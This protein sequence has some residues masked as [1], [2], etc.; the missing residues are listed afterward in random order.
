MIQIQM[1][2]K[3]TIL[4]HLGLAISFFMKGNQVTRPVQP[5]L[6]RE[7]LARQQNMALTDKILRITIK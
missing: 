3:K 2:M 4:K 7:Q 1:M 6:E 5:P